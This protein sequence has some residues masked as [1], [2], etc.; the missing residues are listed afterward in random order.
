MTTVLNKLLSAKWPIKDKQIKEL[1]NGL[2][3]KETLETA[4]VLR[5]LLNACEGD[6]L[7]IER[8]FDRVD[9]KVAQ[10]L[11]GEGFENRIINII[12]KNGKPTEE[13]LIT[14]IRDN[15]ERIPK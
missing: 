11:I 4:I 15:S 7:A 5:R 1:I 8:I 2:K 3:L 10:T 14:K 6:D 12:H 9:G 13:N